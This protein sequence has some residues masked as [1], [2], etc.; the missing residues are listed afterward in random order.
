MI[1]QFTVLT[2]YPQIF[3]G[4]LACSVIGKALKRNIW[5]LDVLDI[6]R[7]A[8]KNRV[9]SPPYGGGGG[10][11]MRSDV[12]GC[13]LDHVLNK[14]HHYIIYTTPR[15]KIFNQKFIE[16]IIDVKNIAILCG[17]FEGVDQRVIDYY[18]IQEVSLC[19]AVLAGGELAAMV[20]IESFIRLLPGVLGNSESAS[21]DS[22]ALDGLL[23]HHQYTKPRDWKELAVPGV[24]LSGDHSKIKMWR[25]INSE[26]LT[27]IR[28]PDLWYHYIKRKC[29][30]V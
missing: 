8:A 21:K 10:M 7:F 14:K 18:N 24:L 23:E 11:V 9:D 26:Q 3:P 27:K 2:L 19:D 28:R 29:N 6:R 30:Y 13:A 15:G 17:R 1:Y 25:K 4:P 20:I 5:S 12:V 22:F 16:S